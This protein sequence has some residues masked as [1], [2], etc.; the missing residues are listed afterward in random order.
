MPTYQ[1]SVDG[2][3]ACGKSTLARGLADKLGFLYIDSGAMYRGATLFFLENNI[4]FGAQPHDSVLTDMDIRFEYQPGKADKLLLN[5]RDVSSGLRTGPVNDHVSQ[6]A[7]MSNVRKRLVALQ[8][9]YG[10]EYNVVM[11]GRDIGTVVFPEAILKIFL[12]ADLETRIGRRMNDVKVTGQEAEYED[13]KKNLLQRDH[14]DSTR[15]DSPLVQASDAVLIDNTNLTIEE[16]LG[17]VHLLAQMRI[18]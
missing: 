5:G 7:A 10:Q 1:I 15:L 17:M 18:G 13:V 12:T 4:S 16:Q 6:V 14:I 2:Y 8:Q 9:S 11:D 3:A